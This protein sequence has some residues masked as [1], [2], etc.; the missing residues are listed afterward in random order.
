MTHQCRNN[1]LFSSLGKKTRIA[2]ALVFAG[3]L[4]LYIFQASGNVVLKQEV[5]AQQIKIA[6]LSQE[7]EELM[8]KALDAA[9]L[10]EIEREAKASGFVR[11]DDVAYVQVTD[12]QVARE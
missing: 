8:I 12:T 2:L 5:N 4:S 3:A 1:S 9:S 6:E 10:A 7:H 11:L